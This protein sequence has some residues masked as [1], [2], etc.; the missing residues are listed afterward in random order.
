MQP[1]HSNFPGSF[2]YFRFARHLL[3]MEISG[4][5]DQNGAEMNWG[6]N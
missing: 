1:I 3:R 6:G 5:R 2:D 4:N